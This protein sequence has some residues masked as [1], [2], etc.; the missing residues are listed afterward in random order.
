[1]LGR[2]PG[3]SEQK[4][5][6]EP[7]SRAHFE[8]YRTPCCSGL[9]STAHLPSTG[10]GKVLSVFNAPSLSVLTVPLRRKSHCP[11]S[12]FGAWGTVRLSDVARIH[13]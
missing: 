10:E 9:K 4:S 5:H 7:S 2:W 13:H 11:I 8:N 1:M 6:R 12:Q 3:V